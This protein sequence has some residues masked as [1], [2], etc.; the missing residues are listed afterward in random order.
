MSKAALFLLVFSLAISTGA[1]AQG[2]SYGEVPRVELGA[3]FDINYLNGLGE[4]GGG[5]GVRFHYNFDP[6]FAID[7]QLVYR[8]QNLLTAIGT[9]T[10]TIGQTTGLFGV[11]AGQRV[12]NYGFFVHARAGFLHFGSDKGVT[13]LTRNTVPA[14][15]VGGTLDHYSGP[16]ILRLELGEQIIA[17]GNALIFPS[18]APPVLPGRLGTRASPVVGLGFAVRF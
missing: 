17:Y 8:Q 6:H 1:Q 7:S 16:V 15:D 9:A 12:E 13:Q 2:I 14:F 11:R 5:I 18:L 10:A 4:W 3:Q